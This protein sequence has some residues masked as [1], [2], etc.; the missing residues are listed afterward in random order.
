MSDLERWEDVKEDIRHRINFVDLVEDYVS[1]ERRGDSYW[2]LCPFHAEKTPS[3]CVTPSMGIFKCFG[4]GE[5]GDI[6]EFFMKIENCEFMDA[7]E[8]LARRASVELPDQ[9]QTEKSDSLH[10]KLIEINEYALDCYR[11]AF[12][13]EPGE[14]A[15]EY[16]A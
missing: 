9:G 1:L 13:N 4:C 10:G 3:F 15:R 5:G 2:G 16:L 14:K 7:L 12:A 11:R 8:M 6:F